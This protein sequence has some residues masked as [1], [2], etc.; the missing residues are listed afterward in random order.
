MPVSL[1]SELL[2]LTDLQD[3]DQL[4]ALEECLTRAFLTGGL[5]HEDKAALLEVFERFP[6]EDGFGV[7]WSILH[8]LEH[9]DDYE[10]E[11]VQSV[12]RRPGL[13]N[14]LMLNRMLNAGI[15]LVAGE[16]ID[17]LL[18]ELLSHPAANDS[19][20]KQ[21]QGFIDRREARRQ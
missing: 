11:L 12:R 13:F 20:V 1:R 4:K 5:S 21:V 14:T 8:G 19:V 18:R 6:D 2:V 17:G 16:S 15:E 7:F 9:V 3:S 10:D